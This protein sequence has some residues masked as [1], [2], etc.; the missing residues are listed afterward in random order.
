RD[1][2][3]ANV[4]GG[5]AV[6]D[7]VFT[8]VIESMVGDQWVING[9]TIQVDPS[10]IQD[11]SFQVGD[12][13]KVEGS[14]AG[15]GSVIAQRLETPSAAD[16]VDDNASATEPAPTPAAG[17]SAAQPLVFDDSGTEAFGT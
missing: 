1:G 7:V 5:K 9:Q 2:A 17:D 8:G 11:G 3:P 15:N 6:S 16:L 10:V 13:V 14:V 12:T 4:G